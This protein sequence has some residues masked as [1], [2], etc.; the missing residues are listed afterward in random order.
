MSNHYK[1][2]LLWNFFPG[3]RSAR[4]RGK[5]SDSLWNLQTERMS[6]AVLTSLYKN[7]FKSEKMFKIRFTYYNAW[8]V[9]LVQPTE[10]G[11]KAIKTIGEKERYQHAGDLQ[12]TAPKDRECANEPNGARTTSWLL[13]QMCY[14][15]RL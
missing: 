2:D 7:T 15:H 1:Q 6:I 8:I 9:A 14:I 4:A 11:F 13:S 12:A 5:C 10:T 3:T